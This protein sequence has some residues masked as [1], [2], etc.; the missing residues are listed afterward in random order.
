[1]EYNWL[2]HSEKH[3][4]LEWLR[5]DMDNK[6]SE[7][8]QKTQFKLDYSELQKKPNAL[9]EIQ[10]YLMELWDSARIEAKRNFDLEHL[11]LVKQAEIEKLKEEI[12]QLNLEK[13]F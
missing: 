7:Y 13:Q 4:L 5:Q 3:Y 12:K 11:L 10:S 6:L 2:I 8:K 9:L 1:M